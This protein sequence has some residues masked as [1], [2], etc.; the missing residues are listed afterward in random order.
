M[1]SL[2]STSLVGMHFEFHL[3]NSMMLHLLLQL[4]R[5]FLLL[6][7]KLIIQLGCLYYLC[8][9][10]MATCIQQQHGYI[11]LLAGGGSIVVPSLLY[12]TEC[13]SFCKKAHQLDGSPEYLI[14]QIIFPLFSE[15]LVDFFVS[16][17]VYFPWL[18]NRF[19]RL[20]RYE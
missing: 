20:Y 5:I 11:V 16:L 10:A 12:P 15:Q 9:P 14:K 3:L 8:Y 19:I 18:D 4:S 2:S 7:D 13:S 6:C 17:V 1:S